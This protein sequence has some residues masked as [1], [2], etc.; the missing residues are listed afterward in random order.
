MTIEAGNNRAV[1]S[2]ASLVGNL[3]ADGDPLC[4]YTSQ[5]RSVHI[6]ARSHQDEAV[7]RNCVERVGDS[8]PRVDRRAVP[9]RVT[10]AGI[11]IVGSCSVLCA[12]CHKRSRGSAIRPTSQGRKQ[13]QYQDW[14]YGRLR[15][16]SWHDRPIS[17]KRQ[18]P[19]PLV[20][21]REPFPSLHG[22]R[23]TKCSIPYPRAPVIVQRGDLKTQKKT[24]LDVGLFA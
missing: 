4:K 22:S 16:S 10:T 13:G 23:T 17:R 19:T 24:D 18:G 9:R 11:H 8:C 6:G 12:R 1:A 21:A 7:V 14:P 20:A 3:R 5:P 15:F 2:Q